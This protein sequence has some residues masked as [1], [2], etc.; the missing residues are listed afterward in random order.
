MYRKSIFLKYWPFKIEI[1]IGIFI[2]GVLTTKWTKCF[3]ISISY[4]KFLCHSIVSW[5]RLD[6]H[7]KN[8]GKTCALSVLYAQ[9]LNK[10]YFFLVNASCIKFCVV[11]CSN[12]RVKITS[13]LKT[14][15]T[16]CQFWNWPRNS[17]RWRY[18]YSFSGA[19]Y[20]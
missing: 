19:I 18:S 15:S 20:R 10:Y 4:F 14:Y 13:S 1:A 8:A 12:S 3:L 17:N 11:P 7:K 6:Y 2:D 16:H 9:K 5:T